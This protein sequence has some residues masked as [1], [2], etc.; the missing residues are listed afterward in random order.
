MPR[1]GCEQLA[2]AKP[3]ACV[4][5][6]RGLQLVVDRAHL[7]WQPEFALVPVECSQRVPLDKVWVSAA[8]VKVSHDSAFKGAPAPTLTLDAFEIAVLPVPT[9]LCRTMEA[10]QHVEQ[11]LHIQGLAPETTAKE[12]ATRFEPFGMVSD[13]VVVRERANADGTYDE[14]TPSRGF[15][16][17]TLRARDAEAIAN[18]LRTY[19]GLRW[20]AKVLKISYANEFYRDRIA[21]EKREAELGGAGLDS[22]TGERGEGEDMSWAPPTE[23]RIRGDQAKQVQIINPSNLPNAKIKFHDEHRFGD[24]KPSRINWEPIKGDGLRTKG[25]GRWAQGELECGGGAEPLQPIVEARS[26]MCAHPAFRPQAAAPVMRSARPRRQPMLRALARSRRCS[27]LRRGGAR[28]A[29]AVRVSSAVLDTRH[30]LST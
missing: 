26:M 11:R 6:A 2:S 29:T 7:S 23:M 24:G 17:V 10:S 9:L 8:S 25:V 16:Y 15:G 30:S 12:L 20:R 27:G 4:V 14:S 19:N 13:A 5:I 18:C 28:P 3:L 22:A 21:R 1:L